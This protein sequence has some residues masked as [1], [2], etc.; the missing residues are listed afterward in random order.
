MLSYIKRLCGSILTIATIVPA[1]AQTKP[2]YEMSVNGVKVIVQPSGNEIVEV[3]TVF[4]GGV[5]NYSADLAGIENL[6]ITA[7]TECGTKKDSKNSFKDKLDKVSAEISGSAGMDF[8][9]LTLNCIKSDLDQVWP[10]YTDALTIPLFDTTEFNRVKDDA[11]SKLK[12]QASQPDFSISKM[13]RETAFQGK[14]YSKSPTGEESTVSKLTASQAH[15]YYT[16]ILTRRRM[17]IVIVGELDRDAIEKKVKEL[18]AAI[19]EGKEIKLNRYSYTPAKNTFAEQKKAVATN[20]IQGV[21]SGPQP[22]SADFN[23][24]TI[25]MRIFYDRQF[26]EVRTNNGLSYAP[27]TRFNGGLSPYSTIQV[28]TTNP[29]KYIGVM[30]NLLAKTRTQGFTTEEVKNTKTGYVTS[31]YYKMETNSAQAISLASNEILFNNWHRSLTI[32]DDLKKVDVDDVNKAFN[33]YVKDITWVYQGD[34]SK[35]N[36]LLYTAPPVNNRMPESK[37]KNENKN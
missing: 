18:T 26:L 28:T 36:P 22:G 14:D 33:K 20:Y 5:Q 15:E 24:F 7:L 27:Q 10:L 30:D 8:S 4:K 2:A 16:S 6:A 9:T 17:L 34:T 13:A 25:A 21:A 12:S 3:L 11:I 31:F 19:P 1:I 23:A 35:V 37:I 29:D 32:N